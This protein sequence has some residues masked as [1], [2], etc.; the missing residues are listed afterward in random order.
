MHIGKR[1]LQ[2]TADKINECI[3]VADKLSNVSG[4]RFIKVE[5]TSSSTNI[6]LKINEV[7]KLVPER[8]AGGIGIY[9]AK[10][11]ESAGTGNSIT[12]NIIING[13]EQTTGDYAGVEIVCNLSGTTNLNECSRRLADDDELLVCKLSYNNSGTIEQ[14]WY[15]LEG[16]QA[17]VDCVCTE[18]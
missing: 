10:C 5:Q 1:N 2:S 6:G 9:R 8:S 13:T 14:K 16:F 17:T 12:A 15:A 11:T 4:D 3:D 18:P 7:L